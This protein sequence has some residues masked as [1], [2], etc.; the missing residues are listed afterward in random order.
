[1]KSELWYPLKNPSMVTQY[2]GD[3]TLPIYGP[4]GHPGW[5]IVGNFGQAIHAAHDGILTVS[6]FDGIKGKGWYVELETQDKRDYAK[7]LYCH[8]RE[9]SPRKLGGVVS[10]GD[11]IGYVGITGNTTGAHLHF[12][13]HDSTGN[14]IDPKPFWNGLYAQ[15]YASWKTQI[16]M[17]TEKVAALFRLLIK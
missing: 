9:Q 15:D 3:K 14:A 16:A 17:I 1:M 10:C 11:I 6:S 8:L 12:G 4:L 7:T 2:F 5:D 13:V